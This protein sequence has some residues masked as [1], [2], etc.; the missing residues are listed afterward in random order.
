MKQLTSRILYNYWND[1]RG[2]RLAPKR[3]EIEPGRI[4]GILSETFILEDEGD[5]HFPF[6][7]AGTRICECFGA[8]LRATD[9]LDLLGDR[10][11]IGEDLLTRCGHQ[12]AAITFEL[13]AHSACGRAASFEAIVLPLVHP[14]H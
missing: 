1:V 4:A 14:A 2:D 8:E 10:R 6:R 5:G 13:E 9:F 7:L 3:F 12:G 11:D